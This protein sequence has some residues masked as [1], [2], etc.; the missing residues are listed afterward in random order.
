MSIM[1]AI[2]ALRA[3]S[4][5]TRIKTVHTPRCKSLGVNP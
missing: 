1:A 4:I 5:K 2:A 3:Y